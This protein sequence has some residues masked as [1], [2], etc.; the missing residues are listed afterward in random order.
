MILLRVIAHTPDK[1][2]VDLKIV[3]HDAIVEV[4]VP[5]AKRI[6]FVLRR[7]PIASI[8]DVGKGMASREGGGRIYRVIRQGLQLFEF[9]QA[10]VFFATD[11]LFHTD[12][13]GSIPN[14][15]RSRRYCLPHP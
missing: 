9:G 1:V 11:G 10:P 2:L 15:L 14:R 3:A 13:G 5:R 6:V 7:R 12:I 4:Y 8:L